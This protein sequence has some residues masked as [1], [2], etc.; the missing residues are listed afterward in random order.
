MISSVDDRVAVTVSS[1]GE[2]V[3]SLSVVVLG[4]IQN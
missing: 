3:I 4:P 1:V 2:L